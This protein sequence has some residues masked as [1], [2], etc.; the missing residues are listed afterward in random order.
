MCQVQTHFLSGFIT[1]A[2]EV[3]VIQLGSSGKLPGSSQSSLAQ[4]VQRDMV[5]T[6]LNKQ[7]YTEE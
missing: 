4:K 5:M 6:S 3:P 7:I 2:K 1:K